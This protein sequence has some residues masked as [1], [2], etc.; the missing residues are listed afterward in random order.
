MELP[1]NF[2]QFRRALRFA[3]EAAG[4]SYREL[5]RRSGL[6]FTSIHRIESNPLH[7]P[8]S[9]TV[10][11][12]SAGLGVEFRCSEHGWSTGPVGEADALCDALRRAV[13][14][15]AERGVSGEEEEREL[16]LLMA[17]AG[18]EG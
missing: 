6:H 4:L 16:S 18:L 8:G 12:L 13:G 11:R 2:V 5:A 9:A 14:L 10:R 3:R 15:I 1:R 7:E 17:I